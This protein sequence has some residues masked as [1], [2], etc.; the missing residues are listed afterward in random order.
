L[1]GLA[2]TYSALTPAVPV[3]VAGMG[4]AQLGFAFNNAYQCWLCLWIKK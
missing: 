2:A 4:G 3:V 1:A